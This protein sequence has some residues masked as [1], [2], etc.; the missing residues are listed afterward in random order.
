MEQ[1]M[2][3]ILYLCFLVLL[4][5]APPTF[6]QGKP[7]DP[8]G[9]GITVDA[10]VYYDSRFKNMSQDLPTYFN[11]TFREIQNWLHE[12]YIMLNFTLQYTTLNDSLPVFIND[13]S[14]L[15][16]VNGSA[17]LEALKALAQSQAR[18]L[19]SI[20]Y[21]FTGY[22]IFANS[23]YPSDDL[24]TNN[25]FCTGDPA[26]TVFMTYPSISFHQTA[27][28]MTLLTLGSTNSPYPNET[29][30]NRM[31]MTFQRCLIKK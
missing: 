6:A 2:K 5:T 27:C 1:F 19:T 15:H 21:L 20:Y 10:C 29:D 17:T 13:S 4:S 9:Q 3:T 24:H 30:Y 22:D 12:R 18:N 28:K 26:A 7:R 14:K 11:T 23:T 25:T 31:N 8:I 16:S